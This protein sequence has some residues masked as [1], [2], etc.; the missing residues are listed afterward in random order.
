MEDPPD[1]GLDLARRVFGGRVVMRAIRSPNPA[2][3][4]ARFSAA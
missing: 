3:R 4:A 2:E 1:R